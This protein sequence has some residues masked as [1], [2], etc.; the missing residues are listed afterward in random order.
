[1][2]YTLGFFSECHLAILFGA[3]ADISLQTETAAHFSVSHRYRRPC[4]HARTQR[5]TT[6]AIKNNLSVIAVYIR[7]HFNLHELKNIAAHFG[8]SAIF[9]SVPLM[10]LWTVFARTCAYIYIYKIIR[11]L[12][13]YMR[14]MYGFA[15]EMP[16][17]QSNIKRRSLRIISLSAHSEVPR[18]WQCYSGHRS[19]RVE[20]VFLWCYH[21]MNV[22]ISY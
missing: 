11:Y 2:K 5:N 22:L 4:V 17:T 16:F 14:A 3:H 12:Y 9:W 1:M 10:A 7:F 8:A 6:S 13:T 18:E 19:A 15:R 21:F 20:I